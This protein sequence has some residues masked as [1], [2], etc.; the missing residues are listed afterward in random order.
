M[1]ESSYAP[2]AQNCV[3]NFPNFYTAFRMWCFTQTAKKCV[4]ACIYIIYKPIYKH[5]QTLHSHN[6]LFLFL[7]E[8]TKLCFYCFYHLLHLPSLI[9]FSPSKACEDL[10]TLRANQRR[11]NTP[12]AR[13]TARGGRSYRVFTE[14]P[15]PVRNPTN[16]KSSGWNETQCCSHFLCK[17][18]RE[19]PGR[20]GALDL[21]LG[22]QSRLRLQGSHPVRDGGTKRGPPCRVEPKAL[23]GGMSSTVHCGMW[24][25]SHQEA[26]SAASLEKRHASLLPTGGSSRRKTHFTVL[27]RLKWS[28]QSGMW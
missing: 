24:N 20:T 25:F 19:L 21:G 28:L 6:L 10:H 7:N 17:G 3:V 18:S 2:P 5:I 11:I 14:L 22:S 8:K 26:S 23:E 15:G 27:R 9:F 1:P 16:R 13:C 12:E 4:C